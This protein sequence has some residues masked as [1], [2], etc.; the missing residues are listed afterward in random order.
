M[1]VAKRGMHGVGK[2]RCEKS[3]GCWRHRPRQNR[4]RMTPYGNPLP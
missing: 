2:G 4:A 1:Q 3:R